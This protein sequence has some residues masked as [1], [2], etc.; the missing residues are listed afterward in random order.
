MCPCQ[1]AGRKRFCSHFADGP[2]KL[3]AQTHGAELSESHIDELRTPEP[4]VPPEGL[5]LFTA[6]QASASEVHL[7]PRRPS[8]H[9]P[10]PCNTQPMSGLLSNSC[11][12][13]SRH[14]SM[15]NPRSSVRNNNHLSSTSSGQTLCW[16]LYVI[17]SFNPQNSPRMKAPL[18]LLHR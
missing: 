13:H 9:H 15:E 4:Q 8:F 11:P 7:L 10:R 17:I 1:S 14:H 2:L 12:S 16:V 3:E 18:P 5:L 6:L